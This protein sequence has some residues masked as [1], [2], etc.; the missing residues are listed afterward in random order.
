MVCQY[1]Q[2]ERQGSHPM[3]ATNYPLLAGTAMGETIGQVQ[4]Q[5]VGAPNQ[6]NS[7]LVR[8]HEDSL[9]AECMGVIVL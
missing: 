2:V 1:R 3:C 4:G 6:L 7:R 8:L 5:G 9:L